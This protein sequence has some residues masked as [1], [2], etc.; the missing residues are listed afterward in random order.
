MTS[1]CFRSLDVN[2]FQE[3]FWSLDE[4][5]TFYPARLNLQ[6]W[7]NDL[8]S[9]DDFLGSLTLDLEKMC[10]PSKT[11]KAC[12]LDQLAFAPPGQD[13]NGNKPVSLFVYRRFKG[14]WPMRRDEGKG[15]GTQLTV[16]LDGYSW[17]FVGI[18]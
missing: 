13:A 16:S 14:M 4:S 6:I 11:R 1:I 9:A 2:D 17:N 8:I 7:D 3:H 15:E 12:T 10:Q 5:E 18:K